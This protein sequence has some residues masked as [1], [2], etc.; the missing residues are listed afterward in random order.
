MSTVQ[1]Y[2]VRFGQF[3]ADEAQKKKNDFHDS[4]SEFHLYRSEEVKKT[5]RLLE[6]QV[7]TQ[8]CNNTE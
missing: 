1:C 7:H 2:T 5:W 3:N 8:G 6:N 4:Y